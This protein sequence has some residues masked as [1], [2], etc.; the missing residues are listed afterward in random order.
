MTEA[1]AQDASQST[2]TAEARK[3]RNLRSHTQGDWIDVGRL[4]PAD[5]L[6]RAGVADWLG[7]AIH[8]VESMRYLVLA[9]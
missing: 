6:P 9:N 7:L 4:H 3:P 1:A 5:A 2:M 8:T